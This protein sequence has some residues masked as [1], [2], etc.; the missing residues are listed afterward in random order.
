[1]RDGLIGQFIL[2][3]RVLHGGILVLEPDP[4]REPGSV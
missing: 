1:M 3:D 4:A 2:C